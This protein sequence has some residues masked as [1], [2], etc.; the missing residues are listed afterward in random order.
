MPQKL[1]NDLRELIIIKT[2]EEFSKKGFE[3]ANMRDI[4]KAC[5][6]SVGN[7]Y[8]YFK[9]K[10]EINN[11]IVKDVMEQLNELVMFESK[12]TLNLLQPVSNVR[13]NTKQLRD[14]TDELSSKLVDIYCQFPIEFNILMMNSNENNHLQSWFTNLIKSL[15]LLNY[16][17]P[18][19]YKQI[20]IMSK[21]YSISI[22]EGMKYLF[23]ESNLS[24]NELKQ[25]IV[26]F[27]R[28]YVNMLQFDITNYVGG[29]V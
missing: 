7:L 3:D 1:K 22:F 2:K 14:I 23:R 27:F 28:S 4:A 15:I 5:N 26:V 6:I 10:D 9:N 8:R 29:R 18:S 16:D 11:Y 24:P 25:S 19:L 12:N 21:T 13:F 20:D 17:I